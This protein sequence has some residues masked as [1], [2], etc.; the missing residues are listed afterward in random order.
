ML[1]EVDKIFTRQ[2]LDLGGGGLDP[3]GPLGP[4]GPL[5]Y[6]GLPM[7]NLGRPPLPPNKPYHRPFNYPKYV[8]DSN[9]NV[10]VRVFKVAIRAN[11]ETKD[12][13]I[14]ILFGFTFRDIMFD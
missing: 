12:A 13:E 7:M 6:F 11:G 1:K 5:R 8:K 10:H 2:P 4:L 9:P 3:L 14:V